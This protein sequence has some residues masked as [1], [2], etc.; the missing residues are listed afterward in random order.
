MKRLFA[1]ALCVCLL[2]SGCARTEQT[3]DIVILFTNDVHC[4]VDGSIGYAGLAAYRNEA[5]K[6]A[7]VALVDVG[8]AIQG[9]PV[10][11]VS[12]GEDIIG[13]MNA[14]GY[15]AAI[16]GNHEFDYGVDRFIEL[17]GQADFPYLAVNLTDL[18]SGKSI[19][20]PYTVLELANRR[21]AVVGVITPDTYTTST[22]IF[23]QDDN[24]ELIYDF[25]QGEN[26]QR[27]YDAVQNAVD[28]ARTKGNADY[29]ILLAHLG[30]DYGSSPYTSYEVIENTSGIDAVLDGHSHSVLESEKVLNKDGNYTLL[31]STGTELT[32]IGELR[33]TT[34]GALTTRLISDYIKKDV[35]VLTKVDNA[36]AK[37]DKALDTPVASTQYPL[38]IY[39]PATT[40]RIVRNA[41]TNLGD[42]CADAY[43]SS[44]GAEIAVI[45]GGG[46]R[47]NI[48]AGKI[49]YGDIINVNPFGNYLCTIEATGQQILDALEMG[50]RAWPEENGGF[51]Q[52]SG[53]S[54]EIDTTKPSCVL[55]N[56]DGMFLSVDGEYRVGNV[57]IANEPLDPSK[58]YTLTGTEYTL[59]NSGDGYSM[60]SGCTVLQKAFI[61]DNLA[62]INYITDT[63]S[64]TV[65]DEYSNPYGDGRILEWE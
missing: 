49:T 29:V 28:E 44:S 24:G 17:T 20:A 62:L 19:L 30:I 61:I 58:T 64:G 5:K 6:D 4:A 35:V 9:A 54:Y 22:P 13:L 1:F 59:I 15:D 14:V 39:D 37:I 53:L 45:N 38:V 21:V 52:V 27:L 50:A 3:Q 10:G 56:D 23:F 2:L 42:L 57:K 34:Q 16:P 18:Q 31:S 25:A 33:I 51:L 26:G 41:E 60:F 40:Q 7:A 11:T 63:L 12:K 55:L 43:R 48:E 46:V 65:G 47:A 32:S 8:D 36:L